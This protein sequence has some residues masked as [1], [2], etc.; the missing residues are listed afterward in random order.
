ME[1]DLELISHY[2]TIYSLS[3]QDTI[4]RNGC[5]PRKPWRMPTLFLFG[6]LLSEGP[7]KQR[8]VAVTR[9]KIITKDRPSRRDGGGKHER[10]KASL[11]SALFQD[12][13]VSCF[14]KL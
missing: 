4:I 10:E 12:V 9:S 3:S 1:T 11:V 8:Q 13:F 2:L 7:P 14:E 5:P 6:R